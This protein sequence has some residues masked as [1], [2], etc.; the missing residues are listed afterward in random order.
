MSGA[1][2]RSGLAAA[3]GRGC[4]L[5]AWH[6]LAGACGDTGVVPRYYSRRWEE[7]R[8]DAYDSWGPAVYYFEVSDD[9]ATL[10]QVEVYDD[11]HVLRYGPENRGD[12]HGFLSEN[13]GDPDEFVPF[14]ID[15]RSFEDIWESGL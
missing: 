5:A 7:S 4:L 13:P 15:G 2:M 8:G 9:W 12:E 11:G 6:S 14:E 10:R 1:R 3:V